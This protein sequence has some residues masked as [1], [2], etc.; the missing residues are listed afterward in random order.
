MLT[1]LNFHK[2]PAA[3]FYHN[4]DITITSIIP[5]HTQQSFY[6]RY[7]TVISSFK[8]FTHQHSLGMFLT[9]ILHFDNKVV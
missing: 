4:C 5:I 9:Q 7:F 3:Q 8:K 1:L 6:Q 2:I